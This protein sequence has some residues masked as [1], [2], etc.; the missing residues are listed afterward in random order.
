MVHK[1]IILKR[2]REKRAYVWTAFGILIFFLVLGAVTDRGNRLYSALGITT[3]GTI[4]VLTPHAN[5]QIYL[6]DRFAEQSREDNETVSLP[7]LSVGSHTIITARE[8][9]YPWSKTIDL[10]ADETRIL[11]P[12][13]IEHRPHRE[14]VRPGDPRFTELTGQIREVRP[15]S[16]ESPLVFPAQPIALWLEDEIITAHW[17]GEEDASPH[18]F[19]VHAE[20]CI[21]RVSLT[22]TDSPIR[23]LA[24]YRNRSDVVMFSSGAGIY[25]IEITP[26]GV[27]NFQPVYEGT[28]PNFVKTGTSTIAVLDDSSLFLIRP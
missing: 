28:E 15:P 13:M 19:C 14:T 20:R 27:Q 3:S 2:L 16:E 9:V 22:P 24:F 18:A 11:E 7:N 6:N 4:E 5:T 21:D 23:N 26:S 1:D 12:F 25:A 8:G 10:R 17:Q